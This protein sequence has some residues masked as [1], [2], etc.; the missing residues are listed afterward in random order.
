MRDYQHGVSFGSIEG[1]EAGDEIQLKG[2]GVGV[3]VTDRMP[4]LRKGDEVVQR[5]V[6]ARVNAG[7]NPLPGLDK[8]TLCLLLVTS[9]SF[10]QTL[11][12]LEGLR[13]GEVALRIVR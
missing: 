13:R 8:G 6:I 5:S 10:D 4:P 3:T 2:S 7:G 11:V 9:D 12:P 1:V